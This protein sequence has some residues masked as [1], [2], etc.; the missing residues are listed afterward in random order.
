MPYQLEMKVEHT[1]TT[2]LIH[3]YMI[4]RARSIHKRVNSSQSI[5]MNFV[6]H[7]SLHRI[8]ENLNRKAIFN[9]NTWTVV[10]G[11]LQYL[12]GNNCKRTYF[13]D[14]IYE[15]AEICG[16]R[17]IATKVWMALFHA[18]IIGFLYLLWCGIG[19]LDSMT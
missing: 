13:V 7:S 9:F 5:S 3:K 18:T 15:H 14:L 6:I 2:K 8:T 17:I 10:E 4:L 19:K 16:L 1:Y 11:I 12:K